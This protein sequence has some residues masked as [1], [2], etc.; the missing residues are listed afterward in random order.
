VNMSLVIRKNKHEKKS[1]LIDLTKKSIRIFSAIQNSFFIS[2]FR[3]SLLEHYNFFFNN[4]IMYICLCMIAHIYF[5]LFVIFMS[6]CFY[7]SSAFVPLRSQEN[8]LA[9]T[10][11]IRQHSL[12][13]FY[14]MPQESLLCGQYKQRSPTF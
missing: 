6:F 9:W 13:I 4:C 10:Y 7:F 5:I 12:R 3:F 14:S 2:F 8:C 1:H 11:T